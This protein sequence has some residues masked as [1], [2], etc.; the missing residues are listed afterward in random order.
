SPFPIPRHFHISIPTTSLPYLKRLV[1]AQER[2]R[3]RE[4]RARGGDGSIEPL[5]H[6]PGAAQVQDIGYWAGYVRGGKR[7]SSKPVS[8]VSAFGNG[9]V[10]FGVGGGSN[11]EERG[12]KQEHEKESYAWWRNG[13][14]EL[15]E[16]EV[17]REQGDRE[18]GKEDTSTE[19]I[20]F[21]YGASV[22][23]HMITIACDDCSKW[24]H[25][26]RFGIALRSLALSSDVIT[27]PTHGCISRP[28]CLRH[29]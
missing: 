22:A 4:Y 2:K 17:G 10:T 16:R 15:R 24:C 1:C 13:T 6:E 9:Y 28:R 27:T 8:A 7:Q 26:A 20:P 18:E 3:I 25:G 21:R 29:P 12:R 23:R 14:R 19:A 11:H 5:P